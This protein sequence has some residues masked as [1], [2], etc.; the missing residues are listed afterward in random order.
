MDLIKT[1]FNTIESNSN[2]FFCLIKKQIEIGKLTK[3]TD[4][5]STEDDKSKNEIEKEIDKNSKLIKDVRIS[6]F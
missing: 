2:D 5:I 3:I 1:G 6:H 4:M